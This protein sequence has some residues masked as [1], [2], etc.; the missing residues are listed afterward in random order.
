MTISAFNTQKPTWLTT[1]TLTGMMRGIE[2]E[3]LRM[4]PDG[5][6]ADSFHPTKLGSKLTHPLITTDYSES[7][8][9]LITEPQPSPKQALAMLR[10]LH[11]VVQQSLE[12]DEVFWPLSMPCMAS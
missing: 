7:L 10:E 1:D 12:N 4:R 5:F 3:G 2:K 8:L 11:I 6:I 9:E